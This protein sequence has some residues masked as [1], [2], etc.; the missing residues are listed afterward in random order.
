[1]ENSNYSFWSD[2]GLIA[3]EQEEQRFFWA[4][5]LGVSVEELKS[6]VRALHS[7]SYL[8]IENYLHEYSTSLAK[9][10]KYVK[11]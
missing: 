1:M 4:A 5:R 3:V 8:E 6:A 7:L 9:R 2:T 11:N 10:K